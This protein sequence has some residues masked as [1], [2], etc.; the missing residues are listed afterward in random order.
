VPCN[1]GGCALRAQVHLLLTYLLTLPAF[2][3]GGAVTAAFGALLPDVDHPR[4]VVL[5]PLALPE[6]VL[7]RPLRVAVAHRLRHRGPLHCPWP[8]AA[9]A[10][11]LWATG[12]PHAALL[13]LGGLLHVLQDALT[14]MGI[15][16]WWRRDGTA[17]LLALTDVPTDRWDRFL[18]PAC[19]A[20]TCVL[21]LLQPARFYEI[22]PPP[23]LE[24]GYWHARAAFFRPFLHTPEG[25]TQETLRV[26]GFGRLPHVRL[27]LHY[28]CGTREVSGVWTPAG[29]VHGDDGRW[30]PPPDHGLHVRELDYRRGRYRVT[31]T[32]DWPPPRDALTL[33]ALLAY[34]RLT[35]EELEHTARRA[36]L[37]GLTIRHEDRRTGRLLLEA[38][39]LAGAALSRLPRP[40]WARLTL[41]LTSVG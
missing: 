33:R 25:L 19:L 22:H 37:L 35:P 34:E 7:R 41:L 38:R 29:W 21:P 28:A 14:T 32:H 36:V 23:S 3:V 4:S 27:T 9:L 18:L 11:G 31:T 12:H 15:P 40:A 1:E 26:A 2:G 16:V 13:P 10:Y 24:L 39:G 5:S 8:W 17:V 30:Y 20:L 6:A